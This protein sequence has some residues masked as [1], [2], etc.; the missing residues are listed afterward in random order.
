MWYRNILK[1]QT[2]KYVE[3]ADNVQNTNSLLLCVF[4]CQRQKTRAGLVFHFSHAVVM[5]PFCNHLNHYWTV[6]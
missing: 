6:T 1:Q 5:Y 4:V 2:A 3:M